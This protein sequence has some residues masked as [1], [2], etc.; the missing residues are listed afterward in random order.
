M[1][2]AYVKDIVG[3]VCML[4][5]CEVGKGYV[6]SAVSE[7]M[8]ELLNQWQHLGI[9]YF[10]RSPQP[11]ALFYPTKA[12]VD[13]VLTAK[14]AFA[15]SSVTQGEYEPMQI[16]VETNLQVV[17]YL[18]TN[19]QFRMLQMFVDVQARLP[20][21]AIGRL[22]REKAQAAFQLGITAAQIVDFLSSHGHPV[23]RD[24]KNT[25][26]G[27]TTSKAIDQSAS[28]LTCLPENV[29]DQ[30]V[31]WERAIH[32]LKVFQ[33]VV[34]IDM[35]EECVRWKHTTIKGKSVEEIFHSL[36]SFAEK[37]C[38]CVWVNRQKYSFAVHSGDVSVVASQA[39][40]LGLPLQQ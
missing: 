20:G 28:A 23:T 34:V 33:D 17:A 10:P 26:G 2:E 3:L 32:R 1:H 29:I 39:E 21:M 27:G 24:R 13:I 38:I 40:A 35:Q 37:M 7:P 16:V 14:N 25:L 4:S 22:T 15:S 12:A 9:V 31:V 6:F 30:L 18:W 11:G 5:Y 36:V 8:K 19:I